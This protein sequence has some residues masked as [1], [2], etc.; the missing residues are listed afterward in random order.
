[1]SHRDWSIRTNA[2]LLE[3]LDEIA[4]A[5]IKQYG[6]ISPVAE[7]LAKIKGAGAACRRHGS[8]VKPCCSRLDLYKE[9]AG[10]DLREYSHRRNQMDSAKVDGWTWDAISRLPK[11]YSKP[12][13]PSACRWARPATR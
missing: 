8:Q 4:A 13:I 11:S 2:E 12:A 9:H 1:M 10:I 3:P 6:P 7:Y 5:L